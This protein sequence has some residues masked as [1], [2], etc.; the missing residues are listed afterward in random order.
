MTNTLLK[1]VVLVCIVGIAAVLGIVWLGDGSPSIT[2]DD[3]SDDS[4]VPIVVTP[5]AGTVEPA[6]NDQSTDASSTTGPETASS[7]GSDDSSADSDAFEIEELTAECLDADEEFGVTAL[8]PGADWRTTMRGVY[9]NSPVLITCETDVSTEDLDFEW[10]A[11]HGEIQ[12]SGASI[13]WVAPNH[14]AKSE[15]AV[16]VRNKSGIEQSAALQF[17]VATCDCIYERY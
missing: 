14:G 4:S 17:R 16:V 9:A 1:L 15:V 2:P 5:P 12:G 3:T 7:D 10:S 13:T 11:T 8:P 6:E